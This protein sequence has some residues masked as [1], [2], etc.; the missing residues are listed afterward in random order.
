MPLLVAVPYQARGYRNALLV[1]RKR[2]RERRGDCG[3]Q[4]RSGRPREGNVLIRLRGVRVADEVQGLVDALPVAE[5]LEYLPLHDDTG[6]RRIRERQPRLHASAQGEILSVQVR[7]LSD[8]L[9]ADSPDSDDRVALR[10]VKRIDRQI[11]LDLQRSGNRSV[12][13]E[14]RERGAAGGFGEPARAIRLPDLA[15]LRVADR[16]GVVA[17]KIP[18]FRKDRRSFTRPPLV[19]ITRDRSPAVGNAC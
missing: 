13:R 17:Q 6:L 7:G 18:L 14:A 2:L 9:Q 1:L 3:L 11:E 4:R 15:G 10:L 16:E 19:R 12:I 8:H 5:G